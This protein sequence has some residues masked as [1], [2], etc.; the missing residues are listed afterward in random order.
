MQGVF[1]ETS[2]DNQEVDYVEP[3]S[4]PVAEDIDDILKEIDEVED[5]LKDTL[6][7]EVYKNG[8][9]TQS[10]TEQEQINSTSKEEMEVQFEQEEVTEQKPV[11]K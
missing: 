2:N 10:D 9:E 1:E 8:T 11:S 7:E 6:N 3:I 4:E 5:D